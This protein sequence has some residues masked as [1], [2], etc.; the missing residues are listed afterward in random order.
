MEDPEDGIPVARGPKWVPVGMTSLVDSG[1]QPASPPVGTG[2][3][4]DAP[5]PVK[6]AASSD[7]A[8][9]RVFGGKYRVLDR[10]GAGGMAVVYRAQ[11]QGL[12]TREVALKVLTPESALSQ[13]TIARFLKE[14]QAISNVQHPNVV[15]LL[16]LGRTDDGQIYLVME[17]LVGKT[18]YEVMREKGSEGEVFTWEQLGPLML[19]IC[20][21]LQA[22]HK[23]KI[24]H[25]D[26]KPSNCFLCEREDE[27]S[28]IKVLDFGIAKVQSG[29]TSDDSIETPLT[30]EGM[31]LG[32][33]HYAAPEIVNRRPEHTLDGR[34]DIFALGVM[35]YQCLTGTLPF[36]DVRDSRVAVLYKTAH[37]RPEA[38]RLRAPDRG[39][40]AEVDRLVMR[41]MEID[42]DRRFATVAELAGV[43]RTTLQ[44]PGMT[45]GGGGV[46]VS[47]SIF[48]ITPS[49]SVKVPADAA[50]N[51][52]IILGAH[53][54]SS[55][56]QPGADAA[57]NKKISLGAHES[58]SPARP[59]AEEQGTPLPPGHALGAVA[60][61]E[62][63]TSVHD[64]RATRNIVVVIAILVAMVLGLLV[65]VALIVHETNK[66]SMGSDG[67]Q[68]APAPA[69]SSA[70]SPISARA[71]PSVA[72]EETG[73]TRATQST[74]LSAA[75]PIPPAPPAPL[76]PGSSPRAPEGLDEPEEAKV[77][78]VVA[79]TPAPS[80]ASSTAAST[81]SA[82]SADPQA[83][84]KRAVRKRIDE[85]AKTDAMFACLPVWLS[86]AD[87]VF[88]ELPVVV[89]LDEK[90]RAE[91][92]IAKKTVRRRVPGSADACVLKV[93][94]GSTFPAGDG[95]L[96][97]P[98][99]LRF[100]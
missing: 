80:S 21:A 87:N 98:H 38:P 64:T 46:S 89:S 96:T 13:A 70:T 78:A 19:D 22:A 33:P 50:P 36:Q 95:P 51:K 67:Q 39:I 92:W 59:G 83:A 14:A 71:L 2:Q 69:N 1:S 45:P 48:E 8:I 11:E 79:E 35:M 53:E 3:E 20:G 31:F 7:L 18:L 75:A 86:F 97:V 30:Q 25:R 28:Y 66:G 55:S 76:P 85:L 15:Q 88:D 5:Q 40:P 57:P 49:S 37:E 47:G 94:G 60:P 29:G 100:D 32:T 10:L 93:L 34:V 24:I 52:K 58:S 90:G 16:D 23:Q 84:R 65:L 9:G 4:D 81:P 77:L 43:I 6:H 42:P 61:P 74:T 26:M 54:S 56:A 62:S 12:I 91:V 82:L 41:A 63:P 73:D 68:T 72:L 99:T 27:R 17:R 44:V